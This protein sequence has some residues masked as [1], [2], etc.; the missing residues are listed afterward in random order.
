MTRMPRVVG[1]R[2]AAKYIGVSTWTVRELVHTEQVRQLRHGR[3]FLF[4]VRDLD[5]FIERLKK[6]I[7]PDK[8]GKK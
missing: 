6:K 3:G 1:T 4:D 7:R 8:V 2:D 5:T